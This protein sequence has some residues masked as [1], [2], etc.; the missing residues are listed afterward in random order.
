MVTQHLK[1]KIISQR[2]SFPSQ[3]AWGTTAL[4]VGIT[5]SVYLICDLQISTEVI[6]LCYNNTF[7]ETPHFHSFSSEL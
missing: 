3:A 4:E 2:L 6:P 7:E 1:E 5:G